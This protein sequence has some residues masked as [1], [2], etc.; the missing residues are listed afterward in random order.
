MIKEFRRRFFFLSNFY[1]E[2]DGK[3]LEHRFQAAKADNWDDFLRVMNA[4]TPSEAKRLGRKVSLRHDWEWI[5]DQI[6]YGLIVVKFTDPDLRELLLDTGEQ[7]LQE[8]NSWG[9][10]YWGVS[11]TTG[12]GENKLGK[13]L[14]RHRAELQKD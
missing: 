2:F 14:M 11:L 12:L 4:P 5:K 7:Y 8:G 6:M 9:D 10:T 1:E 3:T 13:I